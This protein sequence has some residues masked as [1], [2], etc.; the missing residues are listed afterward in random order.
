MANHAMTVITTA[1]L[2]A[3]TMSVNH[4]V[5]QTV[6]IQLRPTDLAPALH[7]HNGVSGQNLEYRIT[8]AYEQWGIGRPTPHL[9]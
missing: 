6:T 2:I 1:N 3:Q 4:H 7:Y 5:T 8:K 9:N